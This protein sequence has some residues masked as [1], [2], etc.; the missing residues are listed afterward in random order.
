MHCTANDAGV[1]GARVGRAERGWRE[2]RGERGGMR[3]GAAAWRR[4][5]RSPPSRARARRRLGDNK[6]GDGGATS[7][8]EALP[9]TT[10]LTTL[11]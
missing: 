8:A 2:A 1:S 4:A 9:R 10:A 11:E 6:I 7:L 3:E 5:A